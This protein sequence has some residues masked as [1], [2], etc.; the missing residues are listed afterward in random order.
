MTPKKKKKKKKTKKAKHG[1]KR[2]GAG[3]PRYSPPN[4]KTECFVLWP[5]H[6]AAVSSVAHERSCSRS[7]AIRYIIAGFSRLTTTRKGKRGRQKNTPS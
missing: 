6:S 5:T 1:G 7:E 2:E 4:T 3:A